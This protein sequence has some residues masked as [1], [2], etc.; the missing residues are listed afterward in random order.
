MEGS[1]QLPSK[2]IYGS[3][4][5]LTYNGSSGLKPDPGRLAYESIQNLSN[6]S[7]WYSSYRFLI[8]SKRGDSDAAHLDEL[9]LFGY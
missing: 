5:T 3:S 1:N 7:I 2:L 4:W 9:E 6:N 8:T